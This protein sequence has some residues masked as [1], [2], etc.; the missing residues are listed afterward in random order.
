MHRILLL[1]MAMGVCVL[2]L[3][4]ALVLWLRTAAVGTGGLSVCFVDKCVS[5]AAKGV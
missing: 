3:Y 5:R 2:V 1:Y 4:F